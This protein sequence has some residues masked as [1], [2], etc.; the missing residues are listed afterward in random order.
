MIVK[1]NDVVL[2]GVVVGLETSSA[3]VIRVL[4]FAKV[5]PTKVGTAMVVLGT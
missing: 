2:V 4:A 5:C 3:F 1:C